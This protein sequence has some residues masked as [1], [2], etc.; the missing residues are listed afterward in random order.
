ML[1]EDINFNKEWVASFKTQKD[2]LKACED[3]PHWFE[4]EKNRIDKLKE[5]YVLCIENTKK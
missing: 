4:G 5:V 3:Y 2:F 1:F